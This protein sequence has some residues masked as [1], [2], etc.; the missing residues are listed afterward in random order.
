[1]YKTVFHSNLRT[2]GTF[3]CKARCIVLCGVVHIGDD[4]VVSNAG[5]QFLGAPRDGAHAVDHHEHLVTFGV[6]FVVYDRVMAE[7]IFLKFHVNF[8]CNFFDKIDKMLK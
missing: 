7:T 1:M 3:P 2:D 8:E 6:S 5:L 4:E